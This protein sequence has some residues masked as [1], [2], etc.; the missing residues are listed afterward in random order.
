MKTAGVNIYS[1]QSLDEIRIDY[2]DVK[3]ITLVHTAPRGQS[4][5]TQRE[6]VRKAMLRRGK[7]SNTV[8]QIGERFYINAIDCNPAWVTKEMQQ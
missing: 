7:W 8:F 5:E 6:G 2:P 1:Y 3:S 4:H